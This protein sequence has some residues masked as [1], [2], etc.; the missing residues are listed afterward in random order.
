M[1]L[2]IL[3]ATVWSLDTAA[4]AVGRAYPRGRMAPRISPSKTWSGAIGGTLAAIVV[5]AV[6]VAAANWQHP[7]GGALRAW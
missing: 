5:C 1:W 4:Y 2:V 3:V 6:L 7:L